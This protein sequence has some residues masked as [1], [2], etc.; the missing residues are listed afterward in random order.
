MEPLIK[1]MAM[2]T[3]RGMVEQSDTKDNG[4]GRAREVDGKTASWAPSKGKIPQA[5]ERK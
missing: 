1:T 3:E 2:V 5:I 4:K